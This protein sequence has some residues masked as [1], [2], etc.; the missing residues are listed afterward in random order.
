[1]LKDGGSQGEVWATGVTLGVCVP[2]RPRS[3][4]V[5]SVPYPRWLLYINAKWMAATR[6]FL[7]NRDGTIKIRRVNTFTLCEFCSVL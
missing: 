4:G 3:H 1:M 6:V 2:Q 7:M 5:T